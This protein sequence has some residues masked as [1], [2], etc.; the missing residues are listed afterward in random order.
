ML[1]KIKKFLENKSRSKYSQPLLSLVAFTES[2]F[3]PVPPDL[4]LIP[5]CYYNRNK[6]F[7]SI[8]NCTFFSVVG[9][10]VAYAIGY[11]LYDHIVHLFDEKK[12]EH[13]I[14]FYSKWGVYSVLIGG[15]TPIPFKIITLTSGFLKFDF[16]IFILSAIFARG[17]RFLI[18]GLII[19]ILAE[20]SLAFLNKNKFLIF[21]VIPVA[22]IALVIIGTYL[23]NY[24]L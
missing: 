8:L 22:L 12:I 9:G 4:L 6:I 15:F 13:F 18:V 17:F 5:I 19:K 7:F 16:L 2:I 23:Y 21:F 24:K 1:K 10:A 11:F 3:F 14:D 20:K